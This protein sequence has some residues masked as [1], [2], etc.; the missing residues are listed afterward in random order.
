MEISLEVVYTLVRVRGWCTSEDMQAVKALGELV[1]GK[2]P[3]MLQSAKDARIPLLLLNIASLGVGQNTRL[4]LEAFSALCIQVCH[5]FADARGK[6]SLECSR[7]RLCH[8]LDAV[9]D[10]LRQTASRQS[11]AQ[12]TSPLDTLTEALLDPVNASLTQAILPC[13]AA[14]MCTDASDS[15]ILRLTSQYISTIIKVLPGLLVRQAN[16]DTSYVVLVFL[17]GICGKR[18]S[19]LFD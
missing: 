13:L 4:N 12:T 6:L 3:Y 19:L 11:A 14:L 1:V 8:P 18:V 15:A 10:I 16:V 2:A 7:P 17:R 5:L 9:A